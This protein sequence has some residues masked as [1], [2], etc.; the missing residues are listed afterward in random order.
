MEGGKEGGREGGDKGR[1]SVTII[2]SG[3]GLARRCK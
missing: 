3:A 2:T 1:M